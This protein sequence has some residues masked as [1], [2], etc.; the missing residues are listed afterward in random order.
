MDK[1]K[2]EKASALE[3]RHYVL[4]Q[5]LLHEIHKEAAELEREDGEGRNDLRTV[6]RGGQLQDSD[7]E[8]G[9][10]SEDDDD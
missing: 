3:E 2:N 10:V 7:N 5:Q 9:I 6:L 1:I 4:F 8:M